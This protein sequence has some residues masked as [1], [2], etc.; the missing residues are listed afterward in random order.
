MILLP[1]QG[2]Y[3]R[4]AQLHKEFRSKDLYMTISF[5]ALIAFASWSILSRHFEASIDL[6]YYGLGVRVLIEIREF[7]INVGELIFLHWDYICLL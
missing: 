2:Q 4:L 3:Q 7:L 6:F 1:L 5:N